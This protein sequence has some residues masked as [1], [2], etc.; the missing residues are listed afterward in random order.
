VGLLIFSA[1]LM[2]GGVAMH[3]GASEL[4]SNGS[5]SLM[6]R[7]R[8]PSLPSTLLRDAE[9]SRSVSEVEGSV[10]EP[11][12]GEGDPTQL[13]HPS[14]PARESANLVTVTTPDGTE[15]NRYMNFQH[16]PSMVQF[17]DELTQEF[18]GA[19]ASALAAQQLEE[20]VPTTE[21]V[22]RQAS[23]HRGIEEGAVGA[24]HPAAQS[25]RAAGHGVP[26]Q[27]PHYVHVIARHKDGTTFYDHWFHN[28]R[29]NAGTNWQ[30][31]QMAG[32][33]AAVCTYIALSNSGATPSATDTALA[34]EITTNG[35]ARANATAAHTANASSYTLS[36]TFT[37]TGTQAAQNIGV[38][39]ASSGGT[40]CFE[41]TFTQVSMISG[42][43]LAVTYTINF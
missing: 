32:T 15:H 33:T 37:A 9:R 3:W 28:L 4:L 26:V 22:R 18:F 13:T 29:T 25:L 6:A 24:R 20:S 11:S 7:L 19:P 8:S 10:P 30:Y 41:N 35:L 5:T 31:N 36:Y 43:T 23:F 17:L 12:R 38:L 42:D 1:A 40:L 34:S 14:L 27:Y 2:V 21:S 16:E 39:N